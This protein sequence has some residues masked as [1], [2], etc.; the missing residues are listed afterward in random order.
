MRY[1][2]KDQNFIIHQFWAIEAIRP[3]TNSS[4]NTPKAIDID[5]AAPNDWWP[6]TIHNGFAFVSNSAQHQPGN[7]VIITSIIRPCSVKK[8]P[9]VKLQIEC[10]WHLLVAMEI[11]IYVHMC[12]EMEMDG[13]IGDVSP[14]GSHEIFV[15]LKG[16]SLRWRTCI[17]CQ[18]L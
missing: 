9:R 18:R 16:E 17:I 1:I 4:A 3:G 10:S 6:L 11:D 5:M 2:H 12:L 8:P 15:F 14:T 13:C 7:G